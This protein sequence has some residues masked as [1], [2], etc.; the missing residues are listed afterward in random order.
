MSEPS[1]PPVPTT[2]LVTRLLFVF[3]ILYCI[4]A[5]IFL[6]WAPWTAFWNRTFVSL[7]WSGLG[8][9]MIDPWIRGAITGFGLIHLVWGLHDLERWYSRGARRRRATP[10]DREHE[11]IAP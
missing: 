2:R 4:E 9:W 5:G 6:V 10:R 3:Y 1:R 11:R 8:R 7:P